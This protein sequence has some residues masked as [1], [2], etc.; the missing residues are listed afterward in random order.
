MQNPATKREIAA[1]CLYDFANSSFTTV[2]VTAFYSIYFSKRIAE[3]TGINPDLAWGITTSASALL[4]ALF[5]PFLGTLADRTA[6]RKPLLITLA[7]TCVFGTAALSL[8]KPG[9]I[10]LG[11]AL[12]AI[13]NFGFEAGNAQYDAYLPQIAAPKNRGRISGIGWGI[14]YAGGLL[15]LVLVAGSAGDAFK[16]DG[17]AAATRIFLTIAAFFLV[18]ALPAFFLL[19]DR[20]TPTP[21]TEPALRGVIRE[22]NGTARTLASGENTGLFLLA[23]LFYNDGIVTVIKFASIYSTGSLGFTIKESMQLLILINVTALVGAIIF[24]FVNDRIGSKR[25]IQITLILWVITCIAAWATTSREAF[26]GV[27]NLAGLAI[28]ASQSASR[29][30]MAQLAP[31]GKSGEYFGFMAICGRFSTILGP[32]TFGAVSALAGQRQAVLAL[33]LFFIAGYLLL[34]RV[35]DPVPV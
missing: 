33:T 2:I 6:R 11:A 32:I 24:G 5:A 14:G 22:L 34:H 17:E 29:T 13:A 28:G 15:S 8:A 16:P 12:F 30:F 27:A 1:W 9:D 23:Y 19:K 35:R 10:L 21:S 20:G 4:V 25:T 26:W 18:A 31:A 7:L 3:G